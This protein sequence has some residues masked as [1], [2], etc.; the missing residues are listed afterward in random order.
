MQSQAAEPQAAEPAQLA[1][2]NTPLKAADAE[3][4][5]QVLSHVQDQGFA[6]NAF[7]DPEQI[8][9][10]A[11]SADP[12][13]QAKGQAR[14]RHA[15]LAY[16]RAQHGLGLPTTD[17]PKEWG[18][19]PAKY[20]ADLDLRAAQGAGKVQDW[21]KALPPPQPQ[22]QALVQALAAY[23]RIA[24]QGGWQ[25]VPQGPVMREGSRDP[26]VQDLR[27]RLAVEDPAVAAQARDDAWD[28][29]LTQAV[30]R[31]QARYGLKN[32][33]FVGP[34]TY[35]ALNVP[36]QA[37]ID[38]IR[39]N[40]QRWRWAP[41]ILPATRVEVNVP[42]FSMT[43]YKDGKPA[44]QMLAAAGKPGDETPMLTSKITD[45]ELN[46][47]WRIPK[48]I[49]EKEI[50]PKE[51]RDH[52]YFAREQI[53]KGDSDAAPLVQKAGPKSAL[54]Q[55]KFEFDSAYGVYLHD[56]PAKSAFNLADRSVSHGCVRLQHAQD[57]A[58]A[59]LQ[60]TPGW[61][62]DQVDQ[63]IAT[64]DTKWVKL[65]EPVPVMLFYFT[66][67]VEGGQ[68]YLPPDPYGWDPILLRLV[69]AGASSQA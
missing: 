18:M 36:I 22:Y 62:P 65:K 47:P 59:L 21:L 52:G 2:P 69:D 37:R 46:P 54:G 33:G 39:V 3:A 50:Y 58:K 8:S 26:R 43:Y 9:A 64:T 67:Y 11:R 16:A 29:A 28:P 4:A 31:F 14:L 25:P 61:S 38:Q 24:T 32:A 41:R 1:P 15:V 63:A 40:L 45:I 66:A 34:E 57:L 27:N 42:A 19:R 17:F 55:V 51:K 48:D 20:D 5:L 6:P 53:V 56:T 7:G 23:R 10:E 13:A 68:V 30:L 60:T 12:D 44:M 49:A 35:Q